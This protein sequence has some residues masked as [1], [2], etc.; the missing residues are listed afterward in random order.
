MDTWKDFFRRNGVDTWK[1]YKLRNTRNSPVKAKQRCGAENYIKKMGAREG[2][3]GR[4]SFCKVQQEN[5]FKGTLRS[6]TG[7]AGIPTR[8]TFAVFSVSSPFLNSQPSSAVF[9]SF[10]E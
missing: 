6:G 9:F 4:G 7:I 8:S 5:G 3:R 10:S 1:D 2:G